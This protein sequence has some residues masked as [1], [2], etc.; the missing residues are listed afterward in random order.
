LC[1]HHHHLVHEGGWRLR[2][3]DRGRLR[4]VRPDGMELRDPLSIDVSSL[5]LAPVIDDERI[6]PRWSGE[7]FDRA[8]CVDAV[9][10]ARAGSP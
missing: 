8:A 6:V 2:H 4:C 1:W 9:L 3:D 10:A 5:P 7:R